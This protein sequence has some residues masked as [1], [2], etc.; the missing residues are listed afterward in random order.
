MQR[1]CS[2]ISKQTVMPMHAGNRLGDVLQADGYTRHDCTRLAA[3]CSTLPHLATWCPDK[4]L[5][6]CTPPQPDPVA[7]KVRKSAK[8]RAHLHACCLRTCLWGT[9]RQLRPPCQQCFYLTFTGDLASVVQR[10]TTTN[11]VTSRA[12]ELYDFALAKY[13]LYVI[14][15]YYTR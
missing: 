11:A 3:L 13:G 14:I 8:Q 9:R 10:V 12:G 5:C 2:Q 15:V 6:P 7:K 4:S 1:R